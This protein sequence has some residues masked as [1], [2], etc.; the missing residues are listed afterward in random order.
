[1]LWKSRSLTDKDGHGWLPG[2]TSLPGVECIS[3]AKM[4]KGILGPGK[5]KAKSWSK[6]DLGLQVR[7]GREAEAGGHGE[8][9]HVPLTGMRSLWRFIS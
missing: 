8:T 7:P 2:R 5:L 6:T 4:Q 1:M 9:W 3:L